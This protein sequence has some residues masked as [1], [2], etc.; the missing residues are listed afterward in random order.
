MTRLS[1]KNPPRNITRVDHDHKGDHGWI[2]TMQR[3]GAVIV[4]R[5]SDGI[6]GGKQKALKAA[7][8]YRDSFLARDKP[9]DHQIWIRTRLRK[10][11]K[12]GIPGV[13]RYEIKANPN[14]GNVRVY[15]IAAWTNEHGVT[16]Q[17]KFSVAQYGEEEAKLLA[18]AERDYQLRRVVA[19]NAA[20]RKIVSPDQK[21]IWKASRVKEDH[22]G[23]GERKVQKGNEDHGRGAA[24]RVQI[25]EATIDQNGNVTLLESVELESARRALVTILAEGR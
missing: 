18:I 15:W 1:A 10:N 23:E 3:K 12:S 11:N 7:V 19:I 21:G 17:R 25:I 2:V 22:D 5:F 6:Y 14:T 16:R 24:N 9:F 4:K 13:H 20:D 8:E